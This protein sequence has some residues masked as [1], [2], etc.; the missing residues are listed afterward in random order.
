M[1]QKRMR[2]VGVAVTLM[3]GSFTT[4]GEAQ[5]AAGK[6]DA[7]GLYK[8]RCLICHGAKGDSSLPGMS[9]TD[10]EWKNG[11]AIKEISN[12]IRDGVK[13]TAM[14]PFKST[15]KENEIEALAHYVRA[16]DP[17]LK[18]ADPSK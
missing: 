4:T 3:M 12:V 18:D 5:S 16:F 14:L 2:C 10:G 1:M 17:R 15:L 7:V 6:A 8:G 13:G 11:S 9:F